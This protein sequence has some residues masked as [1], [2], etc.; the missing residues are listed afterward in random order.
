MNESFFGFVFVFFPLNIIRRLCLPDI[1]QDMALSSVC[2]Y[3]ARKIAQDPAIFVKIT[4][5]HVLIAEHFI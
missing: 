4:L 3:K 2:F 1:L 5:F